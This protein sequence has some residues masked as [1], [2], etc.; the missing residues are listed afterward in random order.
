MTYECQADVDGPTGRDAQ[1]VDMASKRALT[2]TTRRDLL[3]IGAAGAVGAGV[4]L[5]AKPEVAQAVV[6]SGL[7]YHVHGLFTFV[8]T[9]NRQ[10]VSLFVSGPPGNMSGYGWDTPEDEN[11]VAGACFYTLQGEAFGTSLDLT[12]RGLFAND[13]RNLAG[14]VAVQADFNTG[15]VTWSFQRVGA[16]SAFVAKGIGTVVR[17]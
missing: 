7:A 17:I 3:R 15:E 9:T 10:R 4:G 6:G 13:A 11:N 8:G 2:K 14:I 1:E 12:G 5:A 16:P